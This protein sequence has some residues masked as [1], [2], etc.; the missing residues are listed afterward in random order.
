[1]GPAHTKG[2]IGT[3]DPGPQS[4]ARTP[5]QLQSQE[6]LIRGMG[7]TLDWP[8]GDFPASIA[9]RVGHQGSASATDWACAL[10]L[11]PPGRAGAHRI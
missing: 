1:M 10:A 2:H 6:C 4:P 7:P 8:T 5:G 9:A 11:H 3:Q